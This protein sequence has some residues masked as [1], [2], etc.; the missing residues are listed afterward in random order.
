MSMSIE[1]AK[2]IIK[3]QVKKGTFS[4][5]EPKMFKY[6]KVYPTPKENTKESLKYIDFSNIDV[7]LTTLEG[8]TQVFDLAAQGVAKID[9]FDDNVLSEYHSLGLVRAM[10]IKYRYND[11]VVAHNKLL[12]PSTNLEE[13][14][15][16]IYDALPY[17]DTKYRE[18]WQELAD[19]NFKIQRSEAKTLNLILMLCYKYTNTMSNA[20]AFLENEEEYNKLRS[21]IAA[22]DITF[23]Y[24]NVL[25]IQEKAKEKYDLIYLADSLDHL[26]AYVCYDWGSSLYQKFIDNKQGILNEAGIIA[27]CATKVN[28]RRIWRNSRMKMHHLANEDVYEI[29]SAVLDNN[30]KDLLVLSR[31]KGE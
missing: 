27:N 16:I 19:Y 13:I 3:K 31:K 29:S 30:Q 14:T 5:N 8:T 2:H 1:R 6:Y 17:M 9:T 15:T 24:A 28:E 11:F 12:N 25:N 22:I 4:D 18:Y 7:A 20:C 10:I 23:T 21:K 26:A